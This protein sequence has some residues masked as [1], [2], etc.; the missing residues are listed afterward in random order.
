MSNDLQRAKAEER[1]SDAHDY[2]SNPIGSRD[3]TL[4]WR[5]WQAAVEFNGQCSVEPIAWIHEDELPPGYPYEA[6]WPY[7]KVDGVRL[8]PIFGAPASQP[9]RSPIPASITRAIDV[10]GYANRHPEDPDG[11]ARAHA[12]LIKAIATALAGNPDMR[13]KA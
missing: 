6:M 11:I 5:G 8:F 4:Y 10:Y 12:A 9:A 7:S 13:A 3:W 2:V 1:Y